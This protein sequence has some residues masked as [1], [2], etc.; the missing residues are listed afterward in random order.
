MQITLWLLLAATLGL[1]ALV[2]HQR[3]KALR[4]S[5]GPVQTFGDLSVRLPAHWQMNAGEAESAVVVSAEDQTEAG[6]RRHEALRRLDIIRLRTRD[7]ISP[8]E[9][10]LQ[11]PQVARLLKSQMAQGED[12]LKSVPMGSWPG[13]LLTMESTADRRRGVVTAKELLAATVLPSRQAILIRLS[14]FGMVEPADEQIVRQV[15]ASLSFADEVLPASSGGEVLLHGG[16]QL[17]V[18]AG[19][20]KLPEKDSNRISRQLLYAKEDQWI[21]AELIPCLLPQ[22]TPQSLLALLAIHDERWLKG[23]VTPQGKRFWRIDCPTDAD[24][25]IQVRAQLMAGEDGQGLLM[26][27]RGEIDDSDTM[28]QAWSSVTASIRFPAHTDT[29]ELMENGAEEV[30]RLKAQALPKLLGEPQEEQWWLW[31]SAAH[32]HYVG[33]S[34]ERFLP[35]SHPSALRETRW[36]DAQ[37]ERLVKVKQQWTS[38]PDFGDYECDSTRW[39]A[40]QA[41]DENFTRLPRF[42]TTVRKGELTIRH[43]QGPATAPLLTRSV[44]E[45]YLPGAWLPML[46]GDLSARR[47]ILHTDSFVEL[48]GSPLPEVLT[49]IIEP[50][51]EGGAVVPP[52]SV[53]PP[54]DVQSPATQASKPLRWVSVQVNGSGVISRW[55]F[56]AGDDEL[57]MI[58]FAGGMRRVPT[59]PSKLRQ[60]FD[61]PRMEP[62]EGD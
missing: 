25:L 28:D 21:S 52:A 48:E 45:Q 59:T 23:K 62:A 60:D 54:A 17:A 4:V 47:M 14:G 22:T 56:E 43:G 29:A 58:D 11:D 6:Q 26:I 61:D 1:A 5:L 44:S 12:S 34:H 10:L 36:R 3:Q 20:R 33:W 19:F 16:I 55:Y 40:G 13:I 7:F 42:T 50:G 24:E 39:E 18:P 38:A 8:L 35:G 31:Y 46:I 49:L 57:K 9:I 27:F 53:S 15:A 30:R 37:H 32:S 2:D 51:E 41:G